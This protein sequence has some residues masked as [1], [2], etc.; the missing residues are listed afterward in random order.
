LSNVE[1]DNIMNLY[2][3]PTVLDMLADAFRGLKTDYERCKVRPVPLT[4]WEPIEIVEEKMTFTPI[5]ANHA[6]NENAFIFA[7]NTG[8]KQILIG[9]DSAYFKEE[10]WERLVRFR[11]DI[12]ILDDTGCGLDINADGIHMGGKYVLDT[13]TRMQNSAI[14]DEETIF[15]VNHFSHNGK[16]NHDELEAY[17][18]PCGIQVAFDGM[19]LPV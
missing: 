7:V 6:L 17:F 1:A 19:T 4:A 15:V 14:A 11:F 18:N 3:N 5:P 10:I 8:G 16:M 13:V 9:N 12:V 2:G